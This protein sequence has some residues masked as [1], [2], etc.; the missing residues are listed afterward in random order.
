MLLQAQSGNSA[1]SEC[2]NHMRR[3]RFSAADRVN[4]F[5]G[6]GFQMNL[7]AANPQSL[8]ER[9]PHLRKMGTKLRLFDDD[10]S[11]DV[12]DREMLFIQK[13][14]CVFQKEHAVRA[15]PLWIG[16]GKMRP[17]IAKPRR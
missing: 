2:S 10:H 8:A 11:I 17:D 6:L 4:A 16:V 15:L 1:G 3:D 14:F 5:V 12:L 9:L 13:L 7:I